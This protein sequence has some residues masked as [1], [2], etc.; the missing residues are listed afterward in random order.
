M[1][2]DRRLGK[3]EHIA[4]L[5]DAE[6]VALEQTQQAETGGVGQ[7]FHPGEEGLGLVGAR[8]WR[9]RGMRGLAGVLIHPMIRMN[10]SI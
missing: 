3:L 1:A 2:A 7:R 10:C 6:L 9:V 5:G 4:Q 8:V